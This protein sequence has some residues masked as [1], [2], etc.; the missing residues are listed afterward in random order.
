[1]MAFNHDQIAWQRVR[2]ETLHYSISFT[3][4]TRMNGQDSML[5]KI[6]LRVEILDASQRQYVYILVISIIRHIQNEYK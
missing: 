3:L 5:L 4:M 6:D 2:K 1:M